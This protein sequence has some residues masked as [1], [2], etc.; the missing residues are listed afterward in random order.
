MGIIKITDEQL[1]EK[2]TFVPT[3]NI[4]EDKMYKVF[5]NN[6]ITLE[7][8]IEIVTFV[9]ENEDLDIVK[10]Y[11]AFLIEREFEEAVLDEF[12]RKYSKESGLIQRYGVTME[13]LKDY[14]NLE[15]SLKDN[16]IK[17]AVDAFFKMGDLFKKLNNRNAAY[18]DP[19]TGNVMI[20]KNGD[21]KL[22]DIK[23]L[24]LRKIL[25]RKD[26]DEYLDYQNKG[27]IAT[28]FNNLYGEEL[29]DDLPFF[30]APFID[31]I[32]LLTMSSELKDYIISVGNGEITKTLITDFKDDFAP[33]LVEYN[34][35]K[36]Y[37]IYKI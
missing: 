8:L 21:I 2:I 30:E 4:I 29:D 24:G 5:Y 9:N 10:V 20:N 34:R 33:D 31:E 12:I 3:E 11:N 26:Y 35:S 17:S 28:I 36:M 19:H 27:L 14:V 15:D 22:I 7:Q 23:W 18:M 25:S 37:S 1:K 6:E 32:K 16:D 13:Y